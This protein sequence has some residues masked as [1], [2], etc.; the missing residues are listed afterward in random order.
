MRRVLIVLF[1]MT[2]LVGLTAPAAT[3]GPT[4]ETVTVAGP[5]A[6]D[7]PEGEALAAE[8]AAFTTQ[9]RVEV[10]YE[11]VPNFGGL[12]E[13]LDWITGPEAPDL[14]ISPQP[15]GIVE[16]SP[17]L[18]DLGEFVNEKSLRRDFGDYLINL[19][20]VDGAVLGAPIKA[21]L[22][23]LVWYQPAQFAARGYAIPQTFTELIALS[24][25]MVA[26]GDTPWCNYL[27]SG[28]ATGWLGT[29]WVEDLLLSS[30]GPEVYDQWVAH[31]VLFVDPRV[32]AAFERFMFMMDAP[33]YVFDR[34]FLTIVPFF[35]NVFPLEFGDCFM[36]KQGSFF[37]AIIDG[38][39]FDLG[40]YATFK[41]PAVAPEFGDSALGAGAYVAALNERAEVRQLTRYMLSQR[42]GRTALAD[43]GG[44]LL[45]NV[46]F[47]LDRYGDE[48]TRSFAEIV[49]AA[50]S[51]GQFRFDASD[52]MPPEVGTGEFW[53]AMRD[54]LDGARFLPSVLD[55]IDAAWPS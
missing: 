17:Y 25:Q 41:F 1:A 44:W 21:D 53:D 23:T 54:L 11:L 47:D 37:A 8:L 19:V 20:S 49:K 40:E 30:E 43:L 6:P 36:H 26:N 48:L 29:D 10:L 2:L 13:L 24:D 42:F 5:F 35:N 45:P 18:V 50:I 32:E 31:D 16:L 12:D 28:F 9:N 51:A 3:A 27:E 4:P 39:G 52:L 14:I 15:G 55:D 33:G 34:P 7:S 46:R 22:K 38:A